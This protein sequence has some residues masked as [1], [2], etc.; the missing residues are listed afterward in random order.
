MKDALGNPLIPG[1]SFKGAMRSRLESFLQA[2]NP[3]LAKDPA[4]LV[5]PR[6]NEQVKQ[7]KEDY[8]NND[9]ALTQ[10]LRGITDD[11]SKVFGA[12]W[13]AGKFQIRD[14]TVKPG[15]WFGQSQ[16]QERDGVSI[17]RDIETAA[18]GR[19]YDFQVVPAGVE[20]D[21]K[22]VFENAENESDV[23]YWELG[24]ITLGLQQF[25]LQQIPLGGGSSRGLGVVELSLDRLTWV[26]PEDDPQ[27]LITYLQRLSQNQ[28][29][30]YQREA[31]RIQTL[32]EEWSQ[33]LIAHLS[34]GVPSPSTP[35]A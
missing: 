34:L 20:F 6:Q 2:I 26:D 1:S 8:K 22:A 33:A 11:I 18:D 3:E 4:E 13:Q 24:L 14:L 30:S 9:I 17:D 19:L 5:S 23:G 15:T 32:K 25:E 10:A 7:F 21:F 16:Y 27:Q 12:P 28:L 31:E 35:L 29:E